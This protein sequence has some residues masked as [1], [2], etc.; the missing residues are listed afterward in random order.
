MTTA[1]FVCTGVSHEDAEQDCSACRLTVSVVMVFNFCGI[2]YRMFGN[3]QGNF[4]K[5][6]Q[7]VVS[8]RFRGVSVD[9]SH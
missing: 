9:G 2:G 7:I 3:D 4:S 1:T 6:C 5:N 8:E